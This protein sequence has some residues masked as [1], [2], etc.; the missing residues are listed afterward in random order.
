VKFVLDF[1]KWVWIMFKC[2]CRRVQLGQ[3]K[4]EKETRMKIFSHDCKC[5]NLSLGLATKARACN[6]AS[7]KWSSK[8]AFYA[9]GSVGKWTNE[10]HT[11]KWP[12]T[13]GVGLSMDS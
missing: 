12:P 4:W 2:H 11:P 6:N 8:V 7:Q 13:L 10:P 9:L 1:Q 5:R 3:K